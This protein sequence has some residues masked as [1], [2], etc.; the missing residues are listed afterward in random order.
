MCKQIT[1]LIGIAYQFVLLRQ[2]RCRGGMAMTTVGLCLHGD[3]C[4]GKDGLGQGLHALVAV[5]A[6]FERLGA[7]EFD[8][9]LSSSR[10]LTTRHQQNQTL[11]TAVINFL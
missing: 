9:K 5:N 6:L 1:I 4:I 11:R 2:P 3:Q 10:F 8:T 7:P